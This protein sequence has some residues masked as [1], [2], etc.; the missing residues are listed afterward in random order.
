MMRTGLAD[1]GMSA[2]SRSGLDADT[3]VF[4]RVCHDP[5]DEPPEEPQLKFACRASAPRYAA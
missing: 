1:A 3:G 4:A 2:Q 5:P